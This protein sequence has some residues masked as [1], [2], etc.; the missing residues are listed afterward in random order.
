M[1]TLGSTHNTTPT[2][3]IEV[4][5]A[6][7]SYRTFGRSIGVPLVFFQHFT[8]NM[9]NW[10]PAIT[11]QIG[12]FHRVI[13]F[14]G[15]GV[16]SSSGQTR[17]NIKTMAEDAIAFIKALGFEKVDVIGFSLGGFV[18]QQILIDSPS[19]VRKV[20]LIST[21]PKGGRGIDL[22]RSYI[23]DATDLEGNELFLR[24][25]FTKTKA[26]RDAG[27]RAL[28]R[29]SERRDRDSPLDVETTFNQTKAFE[30]W[31]MM[32]ADDSYLENVLQPVLVVCGSN[33]EVIHPINSFIMSQRMPNAQL[34]IYS[35]SG[36]GAV[37]QHDELFVHQVLYFLNS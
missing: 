1:V 25:F 28:K 16:S 22:V 24:I 7:I 14:N 9:D 4:K 17:D 13:I 10:D 35:D 3:F 21:G 29:L 2:Q 15:L 11:D 32:K 6:K 34:C 27:R 30:D 5:G 37:Y 23:E 20:V 31:G 26:S 19:L 18:V 36:H 12:I 33:D 8:G